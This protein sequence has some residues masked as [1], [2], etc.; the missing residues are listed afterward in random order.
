MLFRSISIEKSSG[1]Y[2]TCMGVG[3]GNLK[4]SKLQVLAKKGNG[5][6]VYLD[7]IREAE[8]VFMNELTQTICMVADNASAGVQFNSNEVSSY[9]LIGFDNEREDMDAKESTLEG[10]QIGSGTSLHILYE[11]QTKNMQEIGRAHV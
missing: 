8:K 9:R 7:D 2:L 5:N 4:D 11:I 3:S 10:G 1:I 6:Y